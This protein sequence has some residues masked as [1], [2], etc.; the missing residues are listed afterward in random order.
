[1][2]MRST[3]STPSPRSEL[4]RLSQHFN[5]KLHDLAAK[6]VADLPSV[7]QSS[8]TART[9]IDHYLMALTATT[10]NN[11]VNNRCATEGWLVGARAAGGPYR[12]ADA[13]SRAFNYRPG[14]TLLAVA[15]LDRLPTVIGDPYLTSCE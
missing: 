13:D 6:L 10:S 12:R 8:L 9:P 4:T 14:T 5:V 7:L 1:M 2:L 11:N 3:S 15:A